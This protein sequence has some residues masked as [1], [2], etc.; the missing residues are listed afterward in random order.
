MIQSAFTQKLAEIK[1]T[2]EG[3]DGWLTD[4]EVSFLALLAA[5]PTTVGDILEIGSYR[6]RSTIVLALAKRQAGDEAR[7]I[8]IDPLPDE[9][10]MAQDESGRWTARALFEANLHRSGVGTE[11]EFHQA[12][13]QELSEQWD[14]PLRLLWID[15]DHSYP[16]TKQDYDLYSPHLANG[17]VLAM[18]DV[19]S[20]YDGCIRVFT[21]TV[22]SSPHFGAAG[23]CG[24]IGWAQ[25]WKDPAA[26][27]E[28]QAS[29]QQLRQKLLPLVRYHCQDDAPRGLS[30]L[31]Y[32]VLRARVPH[33]RVNAKRWARSVRVAG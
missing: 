18:H 29:K 20:P 1:T 7:L 12:Y 5:H 14:R 16:S 13:S 27:A 10:P 6:G 19:L 3:V 2:I 23:L 11:V 31:R 22:L 17:A 24:S 30:K 4:R 33:R 26:A 8:A 15:G 28:F 21:E 32:R 25:F 9:P